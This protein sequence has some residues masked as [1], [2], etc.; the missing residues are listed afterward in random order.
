MS[1]IERVVDCIDRSLGAVDE[2]REEIV[3]ATFLGTVAVMGAVG[4]YNM[5]ES[6]EIAE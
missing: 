1:K 5:F 2:F 4:I 3:A 6:A